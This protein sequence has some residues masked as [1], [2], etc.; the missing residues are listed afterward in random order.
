MNQ[1]D[2]WKNL[3]VEEYELSKDHPHR[4]AILDELKLLQTFASLLEVGCY[5]GFNLQRIQEIYPGVSLA[6]CDVNTGAIKRAREL[7]P[8][9]TFKVGDAMLL[10][11]EDKSFS[12]AIFDAVLMYV[13][14]IQVA[15]NEADRVVRDSIII[16]DWFSETEKRVGH[17]IARNYSDLLKKLRYLVKEVKLTEKTWPSSKNWL[18][19]G[20]IF[21]GTK[22]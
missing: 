11:Y 5:S 16:V 7:L 12:V 22:P 14:D 13:E 19:N 17:S 4:Q 8:N 2:Y 20:Y 21:I 6:G 9:A 18:E 10:P 3:P 15:L 1:T